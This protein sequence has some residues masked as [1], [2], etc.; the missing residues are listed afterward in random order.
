[1]GTKD[2]WLLSLW[3]RNIQTFWWNL[4]NKFSTSW[5]YSK[6]GEFK[7]NKKGWLF[8]LIREVMRFCFRLNSYFRFKFFLCFRI[9]TSCLLRNFNKIFNF[10]SLNF[11]R[12]LSY[13]S[14]NLLIYKRL[15]VIAFLSFNFQ[16]FKLIVVWLDF[17]NGIHGEKFHS[18]WY[19][20]R[21]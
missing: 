20:P 4:K 19:F 13:N 1:M 10:G 9:L 16:T 3:T 14:A 7:L 2:L 21:N 8:S 17:E 12:C 18:G 11:F 5:I 6:F 15:R